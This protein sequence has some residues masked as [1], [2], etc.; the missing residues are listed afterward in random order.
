MP[1]IVWITRPD[2]WNIY[3][4]Q[5]WLDYTGL[6]M[7]EAIEEDRRCLH[8]DRNEPGLTSQEESYISRIDAV[9]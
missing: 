6:T 5:Q 4:N 7:E 8:C 1:Q 2:G 3:F 9:L